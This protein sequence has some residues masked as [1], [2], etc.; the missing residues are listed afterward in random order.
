MHVGIVVRSQIDLAL[1]LANE[2]DAEGMSVTLYMAYLHTVQEVGDSQEPVAHLYRSGLLPSNC[3]VRLLKLP[4]MRSP[5]SLPLFLRLVK[6]MREDGVDLVHIL[7]NPG[8]IWFALLTFMQRHLP[9]VTTVIVPS[10]NAGELLPDLV[11]WTINKL[12]TKGSDVVIVN[13][14]DQIDLVERVYKIPARRLA[15]VPLSLHARADKLRKGASKEEPGT[16]LFFGRAHPHKGLEYLVQAQPH[17]TKKV[18]NA[19]ILISA[20]GDDLG[21]CR[22]MIIDH[23]KF[24][25]LDGYVSGE[26]MA[27]IFSRAA[28][29]VLPY[30]TASTSGV[31]VTA[32]SF[33]KPVVASRVGCLAEYVEDGITGLLVSPTDV[34]ELADAIVRLLQDDDLRQSMGKNAEK[35]IRDRRKSIIKRTIDAYKMAIALKAAS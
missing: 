16:V 19:R 30:V 7:L 26:E 9:V 17:I 35:W 18:Q 33:S 5:R 28:L 1:D 4:R 24:E 12:G 32:Y 2:L 14:T 3:Q 25:I 23:S 20:H 31:L 21:R 11:L 27:E 13:G 29:V 34:S 6:T 10:A 15:Y 8:E 22:Q